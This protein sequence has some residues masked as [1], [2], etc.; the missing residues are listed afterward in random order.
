[1]DISDRAFVLMLAIIVNLMMGGPRALHETLGLTRFG[2][3]LVSFTQWIERKLNRSKR[4]E[5]NRRIRGVI[6]LVFLVI[7][8]GSF[9][10]MVS[11]IAE[12][13]AYKALL[14]VPL[15]AVLFGL[16]PTWERGLRVHQLL[17]AGKV[18]EAKLSYKYTS[19][20]S[21]A[22]LDAYGVARAAVEM[23]LV[24]ISAKFLLPL[25]AFLI[26]GLPGACMV[27]MLTLAAEQWHMYR[28]AFGFAAVQT[29]AV[30]Q[31]LPSRLTLLLF[32]LSA[33]LLPFTHARN[34]IRQATNILTFDAREAVL[35]VGGNTLGLSLGGPLSPFT[36]KRWL[37]GE[38]ARAMPIDVMRSIYV[39]LTSTLLTLL[40][41]LFLL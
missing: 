10:L 4:S 21:Y 9:G 15:M 35:A 39:A 8:A 5:R 40:L 7:I 31:W 32:I 33:G 37:G 30:L 36:V 16:R 1:M 19:W 14:E 23:N 3:R 25:I 20:H 17:K 12:H 27:R 18:E 34:A 6:A 22:M 2:Q 26:L 38:R 28:D 29:D 41:L 11:L 24:H 13:S